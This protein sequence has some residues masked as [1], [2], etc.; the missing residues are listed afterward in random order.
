MKPG[1]WERIWEAISLSVPLTCSGM[2]MSH[3]SFTHYMR[4]PTAPLCFPQG[5]VGEACISLPEL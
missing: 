1:P 2:L 3:R 4:E 5:S